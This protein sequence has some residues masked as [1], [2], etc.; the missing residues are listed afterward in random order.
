MTR[1]INLNWKPKQKKDYLQLKAKE[2]AK[3]EMSESYWK[4]WYENEDQ[5]HERLIKMGIK[6]FVGDFGHPW[7]AFPNCEDLIGPPFRAGHN[8][9]KGVVFC[10][11]CQQRLIEQNLRKDQI[12][13][14]AI[15][16]E[17]DKLLKKARKIL[18]LKGFHDEA[19]SLSNAPDTAVQ[20]EA[21]SLARAKELDKL[22]DGGE[23]SRKAYEYLMKNWNPN[24]ANEQQKQRKEKELISSLFNENNHTQGIKPKRPLFLSKH[25][26]NSFS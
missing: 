23:N 22:P 25:G 21:L 14:I 19:A 12:E 2:L 17:Q 8:F 5:Y 15:R 20:A 13:S 4:K 16:K 6:C 10:R 24:K 11:K 26:S 9:M 7:H 18:C 1:K 3:G